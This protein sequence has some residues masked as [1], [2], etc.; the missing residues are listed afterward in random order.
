MDRQTAEWTGECVS[1]LVDG[2]MYE[3]THGWKEGRG[4]NG[5]KK[6]GAGGK[7][8]SCQRRRHETRV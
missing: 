8:P 5:R 4:G 1:V 3:H 6:G 2:C 7:E